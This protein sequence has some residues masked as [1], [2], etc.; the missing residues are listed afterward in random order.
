MTLQT[1][2][3]KFDP[4]EELQNQL[5]KLENKNS[6]DLHYEIE[7]TKDH[8]KRK[9][10]TEEYEGVFSTHKGIQRNE[11]DQHD[12]KMIAKKRAAEIIL[13]TRGETL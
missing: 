6:L 2:K 12:I 10:D 5:E 8:I 4:S 9:Y 1:T 7:K 13:E 11:P 3:Q